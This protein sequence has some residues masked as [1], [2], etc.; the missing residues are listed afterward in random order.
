MFK[1]LKKYLLQ[2][3]TDKMFNDRANERIRTEKKI[4]TLSMD[5]GVN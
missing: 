1:V 4:V 3:M 5:Q 2:S